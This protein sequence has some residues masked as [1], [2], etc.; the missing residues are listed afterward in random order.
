MD[1]TDWLSWLADAVLALH[2]GVVAFVAGGLVLVPAGNRWGWH[3]VNGW[4]FR[5]AHLGAIAYVAAQ[6]WLGATCPLTTL[7]TS[8]RLRAGQAGYQRSFIGEWLQRLLFYEAPGW[9]FT[10][11]YT[12]FALCVAAAWLRFPPRPRP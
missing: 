12:L 10:L 2:A 7:E 4:W 6:Q 11:A 5:L 9:V 1:G 3:W 8:L